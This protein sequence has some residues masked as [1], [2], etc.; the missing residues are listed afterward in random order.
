MTVT[1]SSYLPGTL[2]LIDSFMAHNPW[3]DGDIT[4]IHSG[5]GAPIRRAL[6]AYHDRFRLVPVGPDLAHR[7]ARLAQALPDLKPRVERF[8]ALEAFRL[9]GRQRILFCDSDVLVTGDIRALFSEGGPLIACADL[10]GQQGL[11]RDPITFR[12]G[13]TEH[14]ADAIKRPFNA[15]VLAIDAVLRG[16]TDFDALCALLH[17]SRIGAIETGHTDQ[18]VLNWHFSGRQTLIDG[19]FNVLLGG[20]CAQIS[21]P[22]L[23]KAK[24]LHFNGPSKPWNAASGLEQPN[25][26]WTSGYRAWSAAYAKALG[27]LAL[28]NAICQPGDTT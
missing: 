16:G 19:A 6:A 12:A 9:P 3:F 26:T 23:T 8:H 24:V 10:A 7:L 11:V 5:D 15:G 2:V 1:S 22:D 25:A 13:P 27:R 17:P 20:A 14:C 21:A 28:H 4:V 18:A